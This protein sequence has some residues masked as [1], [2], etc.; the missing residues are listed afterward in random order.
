M[1]AELT[2][3]G[4][5]ITTRRSHGIL[6]IGIPQD[7]DR[8][9]DSHDIGGEAAHLR[10]IIR[11]CARIM[12]QALPIVDKHRQAS[13]GEGDIDAMNIRQQLDELTKGGLI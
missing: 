6:E 2:A 3:A 5:Q 9:D 4:V 8:D 7:S 10:T 1:I 12:Q 11:D 13:G